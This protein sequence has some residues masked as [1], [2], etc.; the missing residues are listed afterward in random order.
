[1]RFNNIPIYDKYFDTMISAHMIDENFTKRLKDLC[2]IHTDF[3][4]YDIPLE[5]YKSENRIKADYAK[6][7]YEMLSV[8][9]ALDSVATWIIYEDTLKQMEKEGNQKDQR[10]LHQQ[11]QGVDRGRGIQGE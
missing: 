6:I 4:G 5:K 3:G 2:W 10:S 11:G 9:G 8:Y 1:M 7:P